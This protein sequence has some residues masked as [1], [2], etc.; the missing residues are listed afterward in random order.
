MPAGRSGLAHGW[1][2][3]VLH[4]RPVLDLVMI[5][6]VLVGTAGSPSDERLNAT[7]APGAPYGVAPT[8]G[9][10]A[11]EPA[12]SRDPDAVL[13]T[14]PPQTALPAVALLEVK[15]RAPKT[16]YDRDLSGSGWVDVDHDG[17]D[18]RNDI[19][20]GDLE[21][22]AFKPGTR[23]CVVLTGVLDDPYTD[24]DGAPANAVRQRSSGGLCSG[25][26]H[27]LPLAF[28]LAGSSSGC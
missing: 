18:T 17:C 1:S 3:G 28:D 16:G 2:L 23:D 25:E 7:D 20:G 6:L 22:H 27:R 9:D 24:S 13:V 10:R 12:L 26:R 5:L 8:P 15:G 11:P 4:E 19:L 21:P 14:A